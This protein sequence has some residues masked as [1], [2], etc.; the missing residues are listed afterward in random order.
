MLW[1]NREQNTNP[2]AEVRRLQGELNRLFNGYAGE[3]EPFPAV[4]AWSG[5]DEVVI[6]ADIPGV[7]P[8][9]VNLTVKDNVVV[10][11]G[12]KAAERLGENTTFHRRERGTG[13]FMR[14]MQ[15]PFPVDAD[16]V[17]A[18]CKDGVLTITLP[19]HKASK[20]KKI[21]ID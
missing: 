4:N 1:L 15:L 2:F 20:A 6:T 10:L 8:K 19:R 12:E 13:K 5:N 11:E 3:E 17:S 18:K 16:K 21:Q 7:D 14:S 9:A